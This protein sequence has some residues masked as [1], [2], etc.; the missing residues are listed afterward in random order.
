MNMITIR[1]YRENDA[2]SVGQLIA[3]TYSRFNLAFATPENINLLL[4]PFQHARSPELEHRKAI[5]QAI[6]APLV[7]VAVDE[8]RQSCDKSD[9]VCRP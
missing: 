4:G 3:D 7:L 1:R 8:A 6:R 9:S 2:I 5:A